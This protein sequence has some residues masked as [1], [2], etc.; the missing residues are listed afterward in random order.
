MNNPQIF[1][2][3][4]FNS[5]T[6]DTN[7]LMKSVNFNLS[8]VIWN[9]SDIVI[10]EQR[11]FTWASFVLKVDQVMI[12][13]KIKGKEQSSPLCEG[14]FSSYKIGNMTYRVDT[15]VRPSHVATYRILKF[16]NLKEQDDFSLVNFV[17]WNDPNVE[18]CKAIED[19]ILNEFMRPKLYDEVKRRID[20]FINEKIPE[21]AHLV[22]D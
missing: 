15:E 7:D 17:N 1:N 12:E 2:D 20:V 19:G 11:Y 14:E 22:Y 21:I 6:S 5:S 8:N 16:I 3:F 13:G 18:R 9:F 10:N 4:N